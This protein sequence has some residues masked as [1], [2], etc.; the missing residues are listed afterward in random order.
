MARIATVIPAGGT[1][2]RLGSRTPKQFLALDGG[3]IIAATVAHF[4]RHPAVEAI[5]VAAPAAHAERARRVLRGRSGVTVV[6]GGQTRQESV[7]LALQACPEE[8]S[9]VVVH[10]AVR[11]F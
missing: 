4:T 8:A 9:L 5:V 11:P 6:H 10:D 1:G 2:T 7:W 3:P